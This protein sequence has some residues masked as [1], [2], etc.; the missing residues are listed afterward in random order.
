MPKSRQDHK[1]LVK[2]LIDH[3]TSNGLEIQYANYDG[4]EKPFVINRHAPDIIA[5]DRQNQLGY[6]GEVKTCSELVEQTTR[7]QFED[8]SNKLMKSGKSERV[9]LPLFIAVP[10]ECESKIPQTLRDYKL[11]SRKNIHVIGF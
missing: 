3:F 2:S 7:E 6:I 4:Y 10:H 8:F 11:D 9:K 5:F 1:S